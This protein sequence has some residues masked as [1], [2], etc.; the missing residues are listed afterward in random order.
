M[1]VKTER[2]CVCVYTV[3][4]S[5]GSVEASWALPS[6]FCSLSVWFLAADSTCYLQFSTNCTLN[7]TWNLVRILTRRGDAGCT[8]GIQ[9][10][11]QLWQ[12]RRIVLPVN[13]FQQ[14]VTAKHRC[15][16]PATAIASFTDI[17]GVVNAR[18]VTR[19]KKN[20]TELAPFCK[21]L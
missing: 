11:Q 21:R 12:R 3:Y 8:D 18:D 6:I 1:A 9:R 7:T 15:C 4:F 13:L 2:V 14:L 16:R 10:P 20:T 5:R 17:T 19:Q